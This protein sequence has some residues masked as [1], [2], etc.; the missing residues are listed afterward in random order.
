MF[1]ANVFNNPPFQP[2]CVWTTQLGK[3]PHMML[4]ALLKRVTH[5]VWV[6]GT[7][8]SFTHTRHACCY[9]SALN[10]ERLN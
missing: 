3:S 1:V 9:Q 6:G 8:H 4:G 5:D 7:D 2:S 10:L